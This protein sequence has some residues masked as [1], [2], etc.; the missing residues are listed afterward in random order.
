M[1]RMDCRQ[2]QVPVRAFPNPWGPYFPSVV[3]LRAAGTHGIVQ[4]QSEAGGTTRTTRVSQGVHQSA[5]A[6]FAMRANQ[7]A[8]FDSPSGPVIGR[9]AGWATHPHS[10]LEGA[11]RMCRRS[12]IHS[13]GMPYWPVRVSNL[14]PPSSF[15]RS[16][17]CALD[18]NRTELISCA[19][20]ASLLA[21][22][23]GKKPS[24][25]WTFHIFHPP[26]HLSFSRWSTAKHTLTHAPHTFSLLL[27]AGPSVPS[28]CN[29]LSPRRTPW[30]CHRL[31]LPLCLSRCRD[32]VRLSAPP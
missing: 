10:L 25:L 6:P 1:A 16:K 29:P 3:L 13:P 15:A 20:P 14:A 30:P 27:S 26:I 23:P 8:S 21:Q 22:I 17:C 28:A 19:R 31:V 2:V 9:A 24:H 5:P 32:R 18:L 4:S 7:P 11:L 12:F